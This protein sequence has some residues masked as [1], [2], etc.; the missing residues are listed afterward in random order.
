ME[1]DVMESISY[2]SGLARRVTEDIYRLRDKAVSEE[3]LRAA[4]SCVVDFFAVILAALREPLSIEV[5]RCINRLGGIP[6]ATVLSDGTRTSAPLAALV[7]GTQAHAQDYDDTLWTYIG[8]STSV[9]FPASLAVA[10]AV[11]CSGRELLAAFALG[12]ETAHCIG[13][14]VTPKLSELGWHPTPSVGVFGAAAAS[15]LIMG[16]DVRVTSSALTIATNMAAGIRQNFG[17]KAKPLVI[18]LASH[19]GVMAAL[20]AQQGISGSEEAF[21]GKQGFY[22]AYAGSS[23]DSF[24]EARDDELALLSPGVAFKLYPCCTGTHPTIDAILMI[25]KECSLTPDEIASIA[26]EVTPEVLGELIYPIPSNGAEARFSLPYCAA[27]ALVYKGVELRHFGEEFLKDPKI[28]TLMQ[29]IRVRPNEE[30]VRHGGDHC[31]AARVAV[32]THEGKRIQRT[33]H[34][35]RGNPG[36]P[37]SVDELKGKFY[38]CAATAGLS[39]KKTERL[40]QRIMGIPKASDVRTWMAME[41]S[42]FLK[43]LVAKR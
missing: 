36:N 30:L 34:V 27:A 12:V 17:S 41:V 40:L 13:S 8:H 33:V 5:K 18:G 11:A 21:E 43:G 6:E 25:Q 42:P 19:S 4:T 20:F 39:G 23:S 31:P 1:G 15:S 14:P 32:I 35:A 16:A 2:N 7:N 29:R 9:I 10:E 37:I 38:H 3:V 22:M 28:T 26:I 24:E